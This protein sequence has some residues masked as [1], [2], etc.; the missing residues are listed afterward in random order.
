MFIHSSLQ[1]ST[2]CASIS[3]NRLP[4]MLFARFRGCLIFSGICSTSSPTQEPFI[5]ISR[6]VLHF[7][8]KWF[9]ILNM[10]LSKSI[11]KSCQERVL[12]VYWNEAL[13]SMAIKI[14][15]PQFCVL[16]FFHFKLL[17]R[18]WKR[19]T[20]ELLTNTPMKIGKHLV[21]QYINY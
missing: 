13:C 9:V 11:L 1:S 20:I 16:V 12:R 3:L 19:L 17:Q 7:P 4:P 15:D 2:F 10:S 18:V 14:S 6:P 5:S 8:V 21:R